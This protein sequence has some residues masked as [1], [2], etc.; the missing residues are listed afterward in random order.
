[1]ACNVQFSPLMG[2][3]LQATHLS[4][5]TVFRAFALVR[6]HGVGL[7]AAALARD[8]DVAYN[9]ARSLKRRVIATMAQNDRLYLA[10]SQGI[11]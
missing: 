7:P 9:T 6:R 8:L 3:P 10:L 11:E 2:T 5:R 4:L 1:M